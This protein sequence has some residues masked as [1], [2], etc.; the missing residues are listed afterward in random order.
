LAVEGEVVVTLSI[1][2]LDGTLYTGNIVQGLHR[3]LKASKKNRG[4]MRWYMLAHMPLWSLHLV[5]LLRA[6]TVRAISTRDFAWVLRGL[7][8][9][10]ADAIF[11]WVAD[12]YVM[13]RL[14]QEVLARLEAD[15]AKG[16][17]IVL[18]SG[19]FE[20]LLECIS[21]RLEAE[22]ALGMRLEVRDGRYSGRTLPPIP[23]GRGKAERLRLYLERADQKVALDASYAYADSIVDRPALEMVGHPVAVSPDDALTALARAQGWESLSAVSD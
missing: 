16:H 22:V 12:V 15:R 21:E 14:R 6:E 23:S 18:L 1:F 7:T 20:P 2:D 11:A 8:R 13:P 17:R 5:G 9:S 3:A 10:E 4:W 19:T